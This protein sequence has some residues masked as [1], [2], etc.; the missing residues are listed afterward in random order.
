MC[1]RACVCVLANEIESFGVRNGNGIIRKFNNS[2]VKP[3]RM[4]AAAQ[5][6]CGRLIQ[7]LRWGGAA[8]AAEKR[9]H[10]ASALW[11]DAS[12]CVCGKKVSVYTSAQTTHTHTRQGPK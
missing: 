2:L 7:L 10:I 5:R 6:I 4:R 11:P 9:L 3:A 8:S 1:V 12:A